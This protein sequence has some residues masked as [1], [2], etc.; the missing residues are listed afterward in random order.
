MKFPSTKI[1]HSLNSITNDILDTCTRGFVS[2]QLLFFFYLSLNTIQHV[3]HM[4]RTMKNTSSVVNFCFLFYFF[5]YFCKQQISPESN[6]AEKPTSCPF[7]NLISVSSFT[8]R[9]FAANL[10]TSDSNIFSYRKFKSF[11]SCR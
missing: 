6:K 3:G 4:S 5:C 7:L 2:R 9:P 10:L 1:F 11:T 8:L